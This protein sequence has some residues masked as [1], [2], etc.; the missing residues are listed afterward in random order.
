MLSFVVSS[1]TVSPSRVCTPFRLWLAGFLF[2]QALQAQTPA[3]PGALGFGAYATGGRNGTVYHVTNLN[4]SGAGSF[5]DAVSHSGRTIVFDVG[6]EIKLSTAVSCSS[7][8]TIAGQTAPG[9]I[10]F[11]GGEISFA[12]R[13]NIICRYIRIRP[14]SD[15]ASSTDDALSFYRASNI[16]VDHSS[17]AF[18]PWNNIDGVGDSTYLVTSIT[19]QNS[20]NAN[21]TGQQFGCHAESVGGQWSWQYNIFANSHN[22]NPLAKVN[23]TFINNLEY[24]NSA[25]YTTHTSTKFKHDIVNN[26]FVAGPA[27]S[28]SNFPWYQI[29]ENQSIYYSGNM[30]DSDK[31]GSLN[32]S[33]TTPYWYQTVGTI[34]TSPW[35]SWTTVIPT[36][37]PEL[38]YRYDVSAAGAFPR[39]EVDS[40]LLSQIQ[41]LGSGTTGTGAGTTGPDGT[42][43]TSQ[44]QT[45]LGNNGYGTTTGLAAIPDTDGDGM[46]DYWELATGSDP[47]TANPLTNTVTGYTL[48]ENYLN[49]LAAPH[50]VTQ[51]NAPVIIN[52]RQFTGGFSSSATFTLA[53]ATN[54]TVSLLNSTNAQFV[55][56]ADFTGLGGFDF[57]VHDGG[58]TLSVTVTVCVTPVAP[59]A[60][61]TQFGGAII[62][63]TVAAAPLPS[64]L[65]WQGDGSA[66]A[67]STTASNWLDGSALVAFKNNDAVTFDDT[68]SASPDINLTGT[69]LPG[70]IF[71]NADQDYTF[72]GTGTL[73]GSGTLTKT[74]SGTLTIANVNSGF[75]G[76]V[77]VNGSTLALNNGASLGSGRVTL[78]DATVSL[79]GGHTATYIASLTVPAG[80][81]GTIAS[82]YIANGCSGNLTG[83]AA[84]SVLNLDGSQSFS[85]TSTG[86]FDGFPGTI[87]IFSG[88][89]VRFSAA[90]SG[91]TFGSLQPNFI[92]NGSLQPRNAGNT[93]VLGALNGSGQLQGPQTANTG[94][95]NTVFNIGGNNQD[96]IFTGTI[97]SNAN[98]AGSAICVNKLG[99]GTQSLNGNNTF[100]G[101]NGVIAGTLLVNGTITP[102]LTTVFANATLGGTGVI[103]GPVQVNPGGILSPGTNGTG[104][105]TIN[106][107][108][109]NSSPVL[110]FDL[111]SSPSGANDRI[112]LTGTLAMSGV[113]TFNFNLTD[114]A[115]G[116]GTYYLIEGAT[117]STAWGGTA[118]NLPANTRQTFALVRPAAGSN[119][120]YVRLNVTGSASSLVWRG[121]NGS[122]WDLATTANWLNGTAADVFYNLDSV[123]FDD[124]STNGTVTISGT[125][126]PVSLTVA[127]NTLP[128]T[129]G[130]GE[131]AGLGKLIKSGAA[132]LTLTGSNS[133]YGGS[134]LL[135]GTVLLAND[136][137]NQSGLGTGNI[138]L[139]G[140]TL[141]MYSDAASYNDAYWNLIVPAGYSGRLNTDARCNLHGSLTG[142]GTLDYYVTYVRTELDGDWSGFT[143]KINVLVDGDGG[144]FRIN[145]SYGYANA[146][147]NLSANAVAYHVS[148]ST[149]SVG[150]LSG[151][152]GSELSTADWIVGALNTDATFAGSII[153]GSGVTSLTKTGTGT[154]TLTG[155]S[156]FTG[157][158]T[159]SS[160][161]LRANS[162]TGS[163]TGTGDL[164]ISAN[165]TLTGN[166]IIGSATTI[167]DG[168]TLAPG[169]PSGAL[170][171][172]NNLTLND[173]SILKFALGT[174]RDS[175]VVNGD[176]L[177]TGQLQVTNA[178][179]F[180]PGVYPL[181]TC[182]GALDLGDLTLVSAPAGYNYSFDTNTTGVV[183]LIVALPTPPVIASP[184]VQSGGNFVF[185]GSGGTPGA[186]YYVATSTNLA[187]PATN[188]T[189]ILTN[190][191]DDNGNF[192]VTN[193]PATNGQRFY[194]LELP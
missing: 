89:S 5:R 94:T 156:S 3:F 52:L 147:I 151:A 86:Q 136:T 75:S 119:P 163:A 117:G 59:P 16:I 107:N 71:V 103:A 110:K 83:G 47:N 28:S 155:S 175:V 114:G 90:S 41:T 178:A 128:Y 32:G 171:F 142:G 135:G 131:I 112:N 182:S 188:W 184:G 80:Q 17:I 27:S 189:R 113:Q 111:S 38:A 161:T 9:G 126:E 144:D 149:I 134:T 7:S 127:N 15:T 180:G 51:K 42:L 183:K 43:Y 48:L 70:A 57:T 124:T 173:N 81:T 166:G 85:G 99:T 36:M 24:N 177:L 31:N 115:L 150:E 138:T 152:A 20:I 164:E 170:T 19:V 1:N 179:G 137:A 139:Q 18:A 116:A 78:S 2:V 191:F 165:A 58:S 69:L 73:S 46:P 167:E 92:I 6:G 118:M 66:N 186:T 100:S 104:T 30:Y 77:N 187:T 55:P 157:G 102:S 39:D 143:G 35:S 62:G 125:A 97:V 95:G 4:D 176:L 133:F 148:G 140:G 60:S 49:F 14:G 44:T 79:A 34:L 72:G 50:A 122:N 98:S 25:G 12:N 153:D 120:S 105:L 22:R 108:L 33:L 168:A 10:V 88:S 162:L 65:I 76:S 29:D 64:N 106:G 130:G 8:L 40:L 154:L 93:V 158:T 61:A 129:I 141:T 146:A 13:N 132:Q 26:Y 45:G 121:T 193:P 169:D 192:S 56:T 21:P 159:V 190:Q 145:N 11:N 181:F 185:S 91:K 109:T 160:G 67:W 23:D 84:S 96:A 172:T 74:G 82:G 54:G 174:S 123:R 37:T 101:T 53:N 63:V 194:R 87:N 68:G